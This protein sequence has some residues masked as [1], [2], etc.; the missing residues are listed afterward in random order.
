MVPGLPHAG[1]LGPAII[2]GHV[3]SRRFG[4]GVFYHLAELRPGDSVDVARADGTVARFAVDE[5]RQVANGTFR[6][7][8]STA[9]S[10]T[11]ACD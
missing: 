3:D 7:S 6:R 11:R 2:L 10:T 1:H 9:T 5:V 8:R 4:P